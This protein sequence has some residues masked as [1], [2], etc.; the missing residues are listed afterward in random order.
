[1]IKD[2]YVVTIAIDP[3]VS[4]G[5]VALNLMPVLLALAVWLGVKGGQALAPS[6]VRPAVDHTLWRALIVG[7]IVVLIVVAI[8]EVAVWLCHCGG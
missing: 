1:M 5:P 8:V 3:T 7:V 6:E 2:Q 4:L